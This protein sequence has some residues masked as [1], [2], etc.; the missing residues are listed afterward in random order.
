MIQENVGGALQLI[1]T[2]EPYPTDF[3]ELRDLNHSEMTENYL[4]ALVES[5]LDISRYSTVFIGYPVWAT[6]VPQVVL[7]VDAIPIGRVT[8]DLFVFEKLDS[9]EKITFSLAE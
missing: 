7:S 5:N 3:D 9:R 8:S 2:Q 4:P 6:A 1:Q